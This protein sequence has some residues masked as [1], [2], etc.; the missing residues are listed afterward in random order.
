MSNFAVQMKRFTGILTLIILLTSLV[1]GCSSPGYE[2]SSGK[3]RIVVTTN[4]IADAVKQMAGN[5]AEVISIMGPG[6][7]PHSYK[8]SQGDVELLL[9]ADLIVYNGLHLEGKMTE[10]LHNLSEKKHIIRLSD[11]L[12]ADNVRAID[13]EA[14]VFDPHYWFDLMLWKKGLKH[15]VKSA[16][17]FFPEMQDTLDARSAIYFQK[18]DSAHRE[19]ATA[20]NEIPEN[21]RILITSHDAF[22]YFGSAYG[23][24][25]KGLQGISTLSEAGLKDVTNM[26]DFIVENKVKAIFVESSVSRKALMSVADGCRRKGHEVQIGGELFS[27]A[28]DAAGKPGGTYLGM[29]GQ[30]TKTIVNA[31]K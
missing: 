8:A 3:I 21:Q 31:L 22:E 19:V 12:S 7:D 24:Q 6:V 23:L 5:T 16:S 10:V 2:Q 15:F 18:M 30:N 29:I 25:V 28:L 27:D 14:G 9:Q 26:V 11:G 17:G 1:P 4:I 13:K 20:I